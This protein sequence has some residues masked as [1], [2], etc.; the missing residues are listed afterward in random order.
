MNPW[1]QWS[2]WQIASLVL[3]VVSALPLA[4]AC[5]TK[6]WS[7]TVTS[8]KPL[9]GRALVDEWT[10]LPNSVFGNPEDGVSGFFARPQA[11]PSF[12]AWQAFLWNQRNFA[13][14]L[15]YLTWRSSAVPPLKT[16]TW[17]FGRAYKIGWQQLPTSDGW[18]TNYK[19]RMV[20]SV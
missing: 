18:V 9:P 19:Q 17:L 8:I 7:I 1:V 2:L 20:C 10:W 5:A 15:N 16:G 14:G 11:N 3:R 4:V 13:A 6:A 12:S